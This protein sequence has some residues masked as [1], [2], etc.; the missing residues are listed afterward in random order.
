M[1]NSEHDQAL[2]D[3]VDEA[4]ERKRKRE[5][6]ER[7]NPRLRIEREIKDAIESIYLYKRRL[8]R[9]NKQLK[10]LDSTPRKDRIR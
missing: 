9:L 4:I 7:D 10:E 1:G 6:E 5:Q 2:L 3:L 8:M